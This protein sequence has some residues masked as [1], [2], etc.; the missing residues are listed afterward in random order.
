MTY[1]IAEIGVNH[2]GVF[3]NAKHLIDM[4]KQ[5]G[6]DAVKFQ[7]FD[8][9]KL[10]PPGP[11]RDMLKAL[12]LWP[13]QH[14]Y[15]K[16]YAEQQGLEY[17]CTPFDVDSMIFLALDLGVKRIK[18]SSGMLMNKELMLQAGQLYM[19]IIVSTGMATMRDIDLARTPIAEENLTLL[20]CTSA[21]P[22]PLNRCN[23]LCIPRMQM[24]FPGVQIGFSDHS[25]STVIPAAA[26]AL[27]ATVIEKHL[28]ADRGQPGPD[29]KASLLPQEFSEMVNNI[30]EVNAGL[31]D[32]E[33]KPIPEEADVICVAQQRREFGKW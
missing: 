6:A 9:E 18:I 17:I 16:E 24:A 3:A 4:A 19:P 32:G 20:H 7:L 25:L 29:H 26:V 22:T 10:E 11:R 14:G 21:Y 33:K 27:G 28:T 15:L 23:I 31:G 1:I 12:E 30:Y 5:C 13:L 8:A 2:G